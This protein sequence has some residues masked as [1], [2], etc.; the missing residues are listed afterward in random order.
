MCLIAVCV[1]VAPLGLYGDILVYAL[2]IWL[3]KI[4]EVRC[5]KLI[6]IFRCLEWLSLSLYV[7]EKVV[8]VEHKH[9]T[10]LVQGSHNF[11]NRMFSKTFTRSNES[12]TEAPCDSICANVFCWGQKHCVRTYLPSSARPTIF[13]VHV[14]LGGISLIALRNFTLR[15]MSKGLPILLHRWREI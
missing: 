10:G 9:L 1:R 12:P 8:I 13:D 15:Q 4:L 3:R 7:L 5:Y 6:T 2:Q 14:R 11:P